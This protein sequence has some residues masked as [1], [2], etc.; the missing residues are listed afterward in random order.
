MKS[1]VGELGFNVRQWVQRLTASNPAHSTPVVK[2]SGADTKRFHVIIVR[3]W[4]GMQA[5]QRKK[6]SKMD[7]LPES[8]LAHLLREELQRLETHRTD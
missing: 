5:E 3:L 6:Q 7:K 2:V 1:S 4:C 8:T